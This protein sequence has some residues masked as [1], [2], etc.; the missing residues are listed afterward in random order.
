[1]AVSAEGGEGE[2]VKKRAKPK[3]KPRR[4]V[5]MTGTLERGWSLGRDHGKWWLNL[6]ATPESEPDPPEILMSSRIRL[7]AEVLK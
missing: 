5:L 3:R 4:V 7:V 2:A 1:M 6:F